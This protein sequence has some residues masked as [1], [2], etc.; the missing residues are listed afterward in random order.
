MNSSSFSLAG[1]RRAE[2]VPNY[3][4]TAVPRSYFSIGLSLNLSMTSEHQLAGKNKNHKHSP[5]TTP[6]GCS[7]PA[8]VLFLPSL[9]AW[10]TPVPFGKPAPK[11]DKFCRKWLYL[12]L[13]FHLSS[14][15]HLPSPAKGSFCS[16]L[17][18]IFSRSLQQ[19]KCNQLHRC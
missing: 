13:P 17:G 5:L 19:K 12:A 16:V 8:H 9:R 1:T 2:R 3:F 7:F 6:H 4:T 10:K 18:V 11:A 14:S 15:T